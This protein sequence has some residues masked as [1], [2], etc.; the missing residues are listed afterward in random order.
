MIGDLTKIVMDLQNCNKEFDH[1]I[2]E[3]T[4]IANPAPVAEDF[5]L[6]PRINNSFYVDGIITV[7]DPI[8]IEIDIEDNEECYKQIA[9][10]DM[11]IYNKSDIA[12]E[13]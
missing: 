10:A 9:Y 6:D 12:T 8:N 2:I 7:V 1:L 5:Y 3:T 11:F 13:E 4:G